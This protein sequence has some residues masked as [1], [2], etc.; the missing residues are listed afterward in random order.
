LALE[1]LGPPNVRLY[2]K[3]IRKRLTFLVL[4]TILQICLG[5]LVAGSKAALAYPT[6]PKM[7]NVWIPGN[8]LS[9]QPLWLNLVENLA[10]IQFMHRTVAYILVI[11][12]FFLIL[13]CSRLNTSDSFHR[14][15]LYL[16]MAISVQLLLGIFT[17]MNSKTQIPVALGVLHQLGAMVFLL[18]GVY[19]HYV[20]KYK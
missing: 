5:G 12:T 4:L 16:L 18:I 1:N 9:L 15:R 14:G 20:Y 10:T 8:M 13:K 11:Y 6:W 2:D 3:W 7:G 19:L 17:V